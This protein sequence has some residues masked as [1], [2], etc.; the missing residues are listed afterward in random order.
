MTGNPSRW[1]KNPTLLFVLRCLR[2]LNSMMVFIP[3]LSNNAIM[4]SQVSRLFIAGVLLAEFDAT[5]LITSDADLWPLDADSYRLVAN[6]NVLSLNANC[7]GVFIHQ[8]KKFKLL[9]LSAV[10]M[11]S[12]TWRD[13]LNISRHNVHNASDI[14]DYVSKEFGDV[15]RRPVTKE[16]NL[17]W[18]LDQHLISLRLHQWVQRHGSD[19]VDYVARSLEQ[20]RID[21]AWWTTMSDDRGVRKIDAHLFELGYRSEN[22]QRLLQLIAWMHGGGGAQFQ[23]CIDYHRNVLDLAFAHGHL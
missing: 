1:I 3:S 11:S 13:V 19:A 5:Y 17:G 21:R 14:I 9:P 4:L 7:C 16:R 10:G 2:A 15:A 6:K 20:D 22:W 23:W 12:V 18:Y 8:N